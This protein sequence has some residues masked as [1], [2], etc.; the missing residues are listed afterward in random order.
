MPSGHRALRSDVTDGIIEAVLDEL[1]D[2][3]YGRLSMDG[4]AR[5]AKAG[6]A[7]LY[8]RWQSK[9]E[10][11]LDAVTTI[12]VPAL[13]ETSGDLR[14]DVAA[15]VRGVDEWISDPRMMRVL[16]DLLAEA[17]R[18]TDLADA[19][20][21][22]IGVTRRESG[23]VVIVTAIERG[24]VRPDVD[25][26]YVLDLIAAPVFWRICG[27]RLPTTPEFLDRVVGTVLDALP[28]P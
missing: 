24:E 20:T 28:R 8:R 13:P 7:A 25:I 4:V 15:L 9:Q 11:V 16:P 12:S 2:V 17:V 26:E 18:N 10:M 14:T 5:R 21:A 6:K 3:G 19:L 27:R 23:R 1:A 22:R